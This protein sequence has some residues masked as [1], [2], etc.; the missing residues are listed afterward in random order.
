M[1]L[2]LTKYFNEDRAAEHEWHEH[3]EAPRKGL[4]QDE[5][6]Y[7]AV[8]VDGEDMQEMELGGGKWFEGEWREEALQAEREADRLERERRRRKRQARREKRSVTPTPPLYQR[9]AASEAGHCSLPG[10]KGL[11]T[12][13]P[14]FRPWED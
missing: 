6:P 3:T 8:F 9:R 10:P 1:R 4:Y 11:A 13:D 2:K 12:L 5:D 7:Q 14:N